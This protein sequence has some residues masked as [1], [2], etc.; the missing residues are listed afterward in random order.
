LVDG[1]VIP[2]AAPEHVR[3]RAEVIM[4]VTVWPTADPISPTRPVDTIV[5]APAT[6]TSAPGVS[7]RTSW[8]AVPT[9]VAG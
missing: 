2:G 5:P 4:H 9:M 3:A 1:V 6:M 7:R 8:P